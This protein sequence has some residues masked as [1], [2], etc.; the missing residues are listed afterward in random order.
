M[1][2]FFRPVEDG[3]FFKMFSPVHLVILAVFIFGIYLLFRYRKQIKE[4]Y[5]FIGKILGTPLIL[6][7][8]AFYTWQIAS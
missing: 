1:K 6:D 3:R 4:T 7:Q 2:H 5:S 8:T